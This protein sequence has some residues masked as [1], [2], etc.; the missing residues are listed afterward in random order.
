MAGNAWEWMGH[1]YVADY[2]PKKEFKL[3][4]AT[5]G[6]TVRGGSW[7]LNPDCARC[8]YRSWYLPDYWN[9]FIGFRVVLALEN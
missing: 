8:S 4:K 2:D 3:Q 5:D 1:A 7:I 9:S 6:L